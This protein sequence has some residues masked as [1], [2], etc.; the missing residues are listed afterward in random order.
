MT[1]ANG[2][3][4]MYRDNL[5]CNLKVRSTSF[6]TTTFVR[7]CYLIVLAQGPMRANFTASVVA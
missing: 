7:L 2:F 4:H 5:H 6:T 3:T 1:V